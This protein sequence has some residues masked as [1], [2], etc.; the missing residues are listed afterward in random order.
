M[1]FHPNFNMIDE[2]YKIKVNFHPNY[3]WVTIS[4]AGLDITVSFRHDLFG[5]GHKRQAFIKAQR[6]GKFRVWRSILD[7]KF[8]ECIELDDKPEFQSKIQE[9]MEKHKIEKPTV[10]ELMNYYYN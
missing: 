2:G 5:M 10:T 8:R 7:R 6:T 3:D 1:L 4:G 9:L